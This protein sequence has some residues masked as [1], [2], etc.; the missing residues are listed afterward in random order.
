LSLRARYATPAR[1][2]GPPEAYV[3]LSYYEEA[4]RPAPP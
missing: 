1:P 3:D 4:A 2:L